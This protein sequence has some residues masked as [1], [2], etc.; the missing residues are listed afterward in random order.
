ML[1]VDDLILVSV[2]DHLIEPPDLFV[3]HLPAMYLDRA[4]KLLRNDE[5]DDVWTFGTVVMETAALNAVAG[6]PKEDYGM[7]PQSLDEINKVTHENAMRWYSFDP[8][9]HVPKAE[10]TVGALRRRSAG[11]DV[12]VVSRST[13][14]RTADEKLEGFRSRARRAIAAG[15]AG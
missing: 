10:A 13:R 3:N 8:F 14:V 7:E 9:S 1:E 5:G 2:D 12:S 4:P 6:R 11:H 15:V